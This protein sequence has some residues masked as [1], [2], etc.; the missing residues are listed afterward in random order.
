MAIATAVAAK[1]CVLDVIEVVPVKKANE[2]YCVECGAIIRARAVVCP[3]CGVSQKK[4]GERR[5]KYCHECGEVIRGKAAICPKCGVEQDFEEDREEI[6]S[7]GSKKLS[8][9]LC[10]IILGILGLGGLGIHK[11]ILG[12]TSP[13]VIMLAVS[14]G[15]GILT[16]CGCLFPPVLLV[17]LA[18]GAMSIIAI[19]EGIIYL[20]KS[21]EDFYRTYIV[22]KRGWF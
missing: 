13:A 20:T 9:G 11:F 8:A 2:K 19:V 6:K 4:S 1:E 7:V 16:P 18:P 3:E 14:L 15:V 21:D 22:E 12:L 17:L 10:G 5:K